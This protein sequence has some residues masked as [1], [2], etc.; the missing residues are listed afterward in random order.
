MEKLASHPL[1]ARSE[2]GEWLRE[3][4]QA[5]ASLFNAASSLEW[6]ER[7]LAI[8]V[9]AITSAEQLLDWYVANK[10]H[11]LEFRVAEVFARL[12][13]VD[14]PLLHEA[15]FNFV[16]KSP[17]G[18]RYRVRQFLHTLDQKL[19]DF[20][21]SDPQKFMYGP[22][23]AIRIIPDL[24]RTGKRA[25]NRRVW[26]L[27]MDGM[28]YDTWDAVVRPLLMEHFEVVDGQ[29]R[30]YF[31][32]LPSK[33]DIARR[34]L[35]AGSLGKDWKNYFAKPTK[36]ERVLAAPCCACP[37]SFQAGLREQGRLRNRRRDHRG[38]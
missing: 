24:L 2:R 22:R 33:T 32:L 4:E 38:S 27:V 19:A 3:A 1:A 23:S 6:V 13:A 14:D 5:C 20:V 10:L 25:A 21:R 28:R 8:A 30:P 37:G 16:M 15:G 12:E 31:S 34:G 17:A 26:V 7:S 18:L 36:D 9:P 35:L 29:D 11:L